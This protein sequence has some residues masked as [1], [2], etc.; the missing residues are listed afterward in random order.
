MKQCLRTLVL[1]IQRTVFTVK[2]RAST[3]LF[4]LHGH[5]RVQI[6]THEPMSVCSFEHNFPL[7]R[8]MW[9]VSTSCINCE[10]WQCAIFALKYAFL[11]YFDLRGRLQMP[12][13]TKED[14]NVCNFSHT[15]S[16]QRLLVWPTRR[17]VM[18]T[19]CEK[20]R[21]SAQLFDLHGRVRMK[22]FS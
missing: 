5:V 12:S 14:V 11:H 21:P 19:H 16:C 13:F 8:Q 3:P 22:M 15:K 9:H 1:L 18:C 17:T 20:K 7:L 6:L 10:T 4:D 2:R